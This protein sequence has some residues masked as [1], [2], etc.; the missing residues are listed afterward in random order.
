M[1]HYGID[2]SAERRST[3]PAWD[4]EYESKFIY[5]ELVDT[6]YYGSA[7]GWVTVSGGDSGTTSH[8]ALT[9]LD[10]ASANHTGFAPTSHSHTE[11]NISDLD[12][13]TQAEI[14]TISGSLSA[15]IDSDISTHT[16]NSDTHHNESHNVASHS[17]TTATGANLNTLVGGGNTILHKHDDQ[18]YTES[19][20]DG[21]ITTIS[22]KLDDHN[23]LNNLDYVSSGHTGFQPSGDYLTD[24]EFSTYSG[25]LQS[26]IDTKSDVGHSHTESDI[27]NLDKYTQSEVDSLITTISGKLDDHNELNNLDYASAGHTGFQPA[28]D[29]ATDSEL[30]S[31]SGILQT[32]ID[33]K[34]NYQNWSFAVDGVTKDAVTSEDILDFVGGDNITITHSADDQITV[35]GTSAGLVW[36][37]ISSDT[38]AIEGHGYF[39]NATGG[40]VTLTLPVSPSEGDMVGVCDVYNQATTYTLTVGRN[41]Q[42]IESVLEDL[43]IDINGS[44]F[45]LAY[46]DSTR[47][48]EIISEVGRS[49][50]PE[51]SEG[52]GVPGTK[53]F[54]VGLC[55]ATVFGMSSLA[56]TE[57]KN[58]DEY[59]NYQYSDGSIMCWIPKFYY[60][61]A[62]ASNPTYG[63][64]GLNSVDIKSSCDFTDTA[65]ANADGYALHRAFID[66]GSEQAGFFVDKYLC[67]NNGGVCSSILLGNPLSSNASHNPF[68][69]LTGSP[70]N[71]YYGAIDAAKTRGSNF[72]CTTKFVYSALAILSLAHA[73]AVSATTYCAWYDATGVKNY[74]KGNNNYLVDTDDTGVT[75]TSD[76]YSSPAS[77]KTGSGTPF[78]KTTHNGQNNGVTDLNGNM[79]EVALGLVRSGTTSSEVINDSLGTTKFYTL[80]QSTQ[81]KDLT[82]G[83]TS[84]AGTVGKTAWG[85]AAYL[86]G[87]TSLYDLIDLPMIGSSSGWVR[88]GNVSN[89]VLDSSTTGVGWLRTSLSIYL[90]TGSSSGGINLFGVDGLYEYHRSNLCVRSGGAWGH[91]TNAGIWAGY[92]HDYRAASDVSIGLRCALYL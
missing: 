16:S 43:V 29:Y 85:D 60:R 91:G 23:E 61:I 7:T 30:T 6:L 78:N 31:T 72:F 39:I 65:A 42:R 14:N 4:I 50:T 90:D 1:Q 84:G 58:S 64:Y 55:S 68:S 2:V 54:G 27:S 52:V 76:G 25:T 18:Y 35:S 80:K 32:N 5:S 46:V 40:N 19:E 28:G 41:G 59:G 77:S 11:S 33:N 49:N 82:S 69:G 10:Y 26:Q 73:Q 3:L 45:T 48:W 8:S 56:G 37:A 38:T 9:E 13:Y 34:D 21:L 67:S 36:G 83:W 66:G 75:F 44:G 20:V 70:A 51:V 22:G 62:H 71:Y 47:G 74:P 17:D 87:I 92:L 79:W 15:E 81:A 86:E 53:G 63:S 12:K 57:N 88:F 24:S 89:Q